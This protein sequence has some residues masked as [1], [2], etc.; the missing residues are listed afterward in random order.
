MVNLKIKLFVIATVGMA[1][2]LEVHALNRKP[3]ISIVNGVVHHDGKPVV[4]P[5]AAP[6]SAPAPSPAPVAVVS[7][8]APAPQPRP[9]VPVRYI[10]FD[11]EKDLAEA[12][13]AGFIAPNG[14]EPRVRPVAVVTDAHHG[15]G[16]GSGAAIKS[17]EVVSKPEATVP[18]AA[19]TRG[20]K[21]SRKQA[22]E[23][24]DA[25]EA[26]RLAA[27]YEAEEA[28]LAA[29]RAFASSLAGE[30]DHH[31]QSST[32][33]SASAK[34]RV[35]TEGGAGAASAA[36]ASA[37]VVTAITFNIAEQEG[38]EFILQSPEAEELQTITLV[39]ARATFFTE[40]IRQALVTLPQLETILIHPHHAMNAYELSELAG[41][42]LDNNKV[43]EVLDVTDPR[44]LLAARAPGA[45]WVGTDGAEDDE[46]LAARAESA[47]LAARA[48]PK[49]PAR[50]GRRK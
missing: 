31:P 4:A 47:A 40:S 41:F 20:G 35:K 22:A 29:D 33:R 14:F 24:A 7:A 48:E 3:R 5:V 15:V 16:G 23:D 2:N 26:A 39:G 1:I 49:K 10:D 17:P 13:W 21:R 37:S 25:Q 44:T 46:V 42:F 34:K 28:Q 30:D 6:A 9:V 36:T 50:R 43:L 32:V 11:T 19:R 18:A 45:L 12:L 38:F 8:V 27:E